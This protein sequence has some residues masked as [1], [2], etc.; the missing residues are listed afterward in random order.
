D[1]PGVRFGLFGVHRVVG[2]LDLLSAGGRLEGQAQGGDDGGDL[3][4]ALLFPRGEIVAELHHG[5]G[6][7]QGVA[8]RLPAAGGGL[9]V[10]VGGDQGPH[11][12]AEPDDF[13]LR[14]AVADHVGETVEVLVPFLAV[15]DVAAA[16]LERVLAL[17]ADFVGVEG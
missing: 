4:D 6:K 11:A 12:F 3:A 2:H 7:A 5:R 9:A 17:A 16:F 13:G 1:V 15:V 14:V 8:G 10:G